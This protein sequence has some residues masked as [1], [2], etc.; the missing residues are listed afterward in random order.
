MAGNKYLL[1]TV[2]VVAYFNHEAIIRQRLQSSI[3]YSSSIVIGELYF[4]AYN[5]QKVASN[6]Q[7]IHEFRAIMTIL[8][9]DE[10]T[11]DYYGQIK[12]QLKVKGRPVPEN[13]MWIATCA[14]QH[15]LILATRD[16]HF[17]VIN[18]LKIEKW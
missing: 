15:N 10:I 3:V 17:D 4:G 18:G 2:I 12:R 13:D 16:A 11:S 7:Q 6:V 5:S 9:C 1:D 8:P 14:M